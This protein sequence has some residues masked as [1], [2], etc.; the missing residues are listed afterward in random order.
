MSTARR[1]G[2]RAAPVLPREALDAIAKHARDHL[3]R[4]EKFS[5]RLGLEGRLA[6]VA[7]RF[8]VSMG[9]V[10]AAFQAA[11]AKALADWKAQKGVG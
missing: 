9:A 1:A 5:D 10:A 3:L 7:T 6:N 8:E 11:R 2:T 4:P